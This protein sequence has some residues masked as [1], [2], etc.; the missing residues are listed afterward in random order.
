MLELKDLIVTGKD[1]DL[2]K[3]PTKAGFDKDDRPK[4]EA[5][6]EENL[7]AISELQ[8]K[9][10]AD[11]REGIVVLLQALD[12]AGKDSIIKHVMSGVN[13]Q[14]VKVTPFKQPSKEELAHDYLWRAVR[15]LPERGQIAIFNRSYYEDV[16]VVQVHDMQKG[17][18]MPERCLSKPK[19]KFVEERYRQ[20]RAFEDYLYENGYRLLKVFLNVSK[21][22]Q[23]ERFLERIDVE[24]KN[25]K[26][27]A[28]DV[29]ERAYWDDYQRAF[30]DVI[31]A[32][33][34]KESPWYV[35]PADQKWAT[36]FFMSQAMRKVL[37]SCGSKYPELPE[38]EKA[39]LA[40]A[41]AAL[42]A[43]D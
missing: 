42:M 35:L 39:K 5:K 2:S 10:Y 9:L 15:A 38:S 26:F 33:S 7:A 11:G 18:K 36:R 3:L 6:T 29:E 14:G 37:E 34:T 30:Q 41:R 27:S 22:K 20:I 4:I 19:Q 25:W 43:E 13:P 28:A 32:T 17:Y 12:A 23:K 21:E 31:A 8:E 1:F 16:L 24:E 40:E